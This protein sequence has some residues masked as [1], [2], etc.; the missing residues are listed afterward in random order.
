VD[1]ALRSVKTQQLL[2][3]G[4]LLGLGILHAVVVLRPSA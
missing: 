3:W 2:T 4:A 1:G